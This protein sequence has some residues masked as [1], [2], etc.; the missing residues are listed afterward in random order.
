VGKKLA[1]SV[2][3]VYL[4]ELAGPLL[5][6]FEAEP[7]AYDLAIACCIIIYHYADVVAH[8]EEKRISEVTKE[9]SKRAPHFQ[10]IGGIA[11]SAKHVELTRHADKALI[12]LRAEHLEVGKGV[13]F[14]DGS[15]FSDGSSFGDMADVVCVKTPDGTLHDVLFLCQE[16]LRAL[17]P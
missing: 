7:K 11:N 8:S 17:A 5:A 13:A 2:P 16:T 3:D 15:Y 9:L 14:R 1:F 6:R 10:V 12:G 4:H